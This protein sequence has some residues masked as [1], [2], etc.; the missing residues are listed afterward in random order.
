MRRALGV[1]ALAVLAGCGSG[2]GGPPTT[3][4]LVG[5]P[6]SEAVCRVAKAGLSY[7]MGS[8][9]VVK[10]SPEIACRRVDGP[11]PRVVDVRRDR[12]LVVLRATCAPTVGCL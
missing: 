12:R 5:L 2:V 3:G 6:A 10:P 1:L 11:Q 9:P 7:R 4:R 8:G